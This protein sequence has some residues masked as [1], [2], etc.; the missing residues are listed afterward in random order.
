MNLIF[1]D[2]MRTLEDKD[3]VLHV[4]FLGLTI[5]VISKECEKSEGVI[6]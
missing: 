5:V 6:C 3:K 4:L 2:R 1:A